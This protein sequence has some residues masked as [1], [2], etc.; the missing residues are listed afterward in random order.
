[1]RFGLLTPPPTPRTPVTCTNWNDGEPN[2]AGGNENAVAFKSNFLWNDVPTTSTFKFVCVGSGTMCY[3]ANGGVASG[4]VEDGDCS[5]DCL[6]TDYQGDTCEDKVACTVDA[7][8]ECLNGEPVG[9]IVDGNCA[10]DCAGKQ[11]RG[12]TNQAQILTS[13]V[14]SCRHRLRRR[15]VRGRDGLHCQR[16]R[17]HVRA[18]RP[19][20]APRRQQLLVRLL[21][22]R[23][24][25]RDLRR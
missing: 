19:H 16:G 2:N 11:R 3:C 4:I 23:V 9:F 1:M 6:A 25:G 5:C 24:R 18:R 21:R 22:H 13:L 8:V 14:R 15:V 17:G 12:R 20:R 10:C 7:G